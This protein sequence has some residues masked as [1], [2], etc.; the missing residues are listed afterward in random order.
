MTAK[1]SND[2]YITLT[3]SVLI[4]AIA[5]SVVL[6]DKLVEKIKQLDCV[7]RWGPIDYLIVCSTKKD[8]KTFV[9]FLSFANTVCH[10]EVVRNLNEMDF[11]GLEIKVVENSKPTSNEQRQTNRSNFKRNINNREKILN[12]NKL[13]LAKQS[14]NK[15]KSEDDDELKV[16][17]IKPN[18]KPQT[19]N[20][21][22]QTEDNEASLRDKIE[23]LK[24]RIEQLEKEN[25]ELKKREEAAKVLFQL[26]NK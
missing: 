2:I 5:T 22:I 8:S 6:Y 13:Y 25:E 20:K 14:S 19:S 18:I 9:G 12:D 10:T 17:K 4:S 21:S 23:S 1:T 15:R 3:S 26:S 11:L 7:E 16:K 24:T